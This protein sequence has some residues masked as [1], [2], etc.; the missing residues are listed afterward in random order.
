MLDNRHSSIIEI[1]VECRCQIW[2]HIRPSWIFG[3]N[4]DVS[5]ASI[6]VLARY[7][8]LVSNVDVRDGSIF[9]AARYSILVY[10]VN[11]R[12]ARHLPQLDIRNKCRIS[13]S[14][15]TPYS[16]LV[17]IQDKCRMSMSELARY[18]SQLDIRD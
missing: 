10:N 13:M 15:L 1:S 6:F 3:T 4:V 12:A 14:E 7:S 17:D 2:L 11:V 5:A 8:E 18:L 16:S 9:A